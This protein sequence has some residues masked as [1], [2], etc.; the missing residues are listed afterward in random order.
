M[1]KKPILRVRAN[2]KEMKQMYGKFSKI[3]GLIEKSEKSLR[4]RSIELLNLQKGEKALEIGFGVGTALI[5][6]ASE[7]GE[8]GMIFGIDFTPEMVKITKKKLASNHISNVKVEEGDARKLPYKENS[9]DAVYIA[10]TLELFDTP[11]IPIVLSEIR[12]VLKPSGRLCVVSIPKKNRENSLVVKVY[13]WIHRKFP[14]YASC[15]PIYLEN[16][17]KTAGFRIRNSEVIGSFFLMKIV[18][19]V[20]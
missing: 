13:E 19:A 7:V 1:A 4:K 5:E 9:F 2:D 15:R 6:M 8:N 18:I 12:R 14:K 3:I 11:D 20:L 17:L 16:S 10:S